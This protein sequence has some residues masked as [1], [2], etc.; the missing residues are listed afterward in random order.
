MA[1]LLPPPSEMM[2]CAETVNFHN[3]CDRI[4]LYQFNG[5]PNR[6]VDVKFSLNVSNC[7]AVKRVNSVKRLSV[8]L[9]ICLSEFDSWQMQR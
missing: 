7:L 3:V 4:A 5:T 2:S 8:R 6:S 9:S 1:Q